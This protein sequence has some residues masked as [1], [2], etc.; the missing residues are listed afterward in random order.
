[1]T[2]IR[3]TRDKECTECRNATVVTKI[4]TLIERLIVLSECKECQ[5]KYSTTFKMERGVG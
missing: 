3:S 4:I 2:L 1:M 5:I